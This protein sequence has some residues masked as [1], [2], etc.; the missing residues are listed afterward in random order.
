[1]GLVEN[2]NKEL[3][4][5]I[6]YSS[7]S[8]KVVRLQA[9]GNVQIEIDFVAVDSMSCALQ[10]IRLNVPQF[11]DADFDILRQWAEALSQRVTYLLENIGP[12]ELDA[13][14]G[15]VL[16]RSTPP[17]K[18]GGTTLFYEVL[19]KSHAGGNFSLKRYESK[20]GAGGR[21]PVDL[22]TTHELLRKLIVDLID[23][24]PV[25]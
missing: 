11:V 8:P 3:I 5:L 21:Q 2:I 10:E 23:T 7:T 17:Q 14:A 22:Q 25:S 19:L 6:G 15:Q 24:I 18:Q 20:S 4:Q 13:D 1:M 9:T 12:L 16:I